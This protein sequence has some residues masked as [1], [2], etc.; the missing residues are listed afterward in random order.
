MNN[1]ELVNKD[2]FERLR[3]KNRR[4]E[5]RRHIFY[6]FIA[7]LLLAVI[8]IICVVLFFGMKKVEI[9]GNSRYTANDILSVCDFT[10]KT[11][12]LAIDFEE[13]EA[14]IVKNCPY[15]REVHFK[16]ILPSTLIL[17]VTED[18]P[19]YC[20]E[21]HGDW[22]LLSD[23]LR[24]IS[25]HD[26]YEEISVLSLP[27]TYLLLPE[28]DYAVAGEHI[29]FAQTAAYS[30]LTSFLNELAGQPF[31]TSV[32][33]IDTSDRY[34]I[35]LYAENGRYLVELG[36]AENLDTKLRFVIKVLEDPTFDS[37][38]IA[39]INVEYVSQI[40]VLKQDHP[41]TYR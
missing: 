13:T 37:T 8:G 11:N 26:L 3:S 22:F 23:D 32:E 31:Y 17:T 5:I 9:R 18:V 34:H 16:R 7:L 21:I 40:I 33:C 30:Y 14:A 25:K 1:A 39:S 35:A 36:N 28:V 15:I 27:V 6:F 2:S 12:L 4:K 38:T 10:S 24:V 29:R 41:F 19:K 20:A